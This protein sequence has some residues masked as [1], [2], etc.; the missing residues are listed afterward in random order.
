MFCFVLPGVQKV[1]V[2]RQIV[3]TFKTMAPLLLLYII[4]SICVENA[5][6]VR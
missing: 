3:S 5:G 4:Y 2:A 6:V 1:R